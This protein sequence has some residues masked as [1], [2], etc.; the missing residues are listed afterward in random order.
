VLLLSIQATAKPPPGISCQCRRTDR[1]P[2]HVFFR[3][4]ADESNPGAGSWQ[5]ASRQADFECRA[6]AARSISA[7]GGNCLEFA[8]PRIWGLAYGPLQTECGWCG[9]P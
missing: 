3:A 2:G 4:S 9:K 1:R 6:A 7:L 8:E 5:T